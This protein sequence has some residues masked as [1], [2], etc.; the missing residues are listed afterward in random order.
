MSRKFIAMILSAAVAV[1]GIS[2]PARADSNDIAKALLGFT[3]LALIAKAIDDNDKPKV[4][5]RYPVQP[6]YPQPGRP[7]YGTP[8][9]PPIYGQPTW[10]RPLPPQVSKFDLPQSCLNTFSINGRKVQ[11][12]GSACMSKTYAYAGSLPYACQYGFRGD[13]SGRNHIG[14]EPLC[15]RVRGYR[16]ARF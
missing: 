15:L 10:P 6:V 11:L 9:R 13:R 12:F 2:A 8:S 14:Y 7:I 3:A 16:T 4:V 5:N 1:T